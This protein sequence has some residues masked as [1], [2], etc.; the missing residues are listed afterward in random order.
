M[1]PQP[2]ILIGIAA[3]AAILGLGVILIFNRLVTG[4]QLVREGWSGIDVQLKRRADLIPNLVEVVRG[5]ANH[6]RTLLEELTRLR[7]ATLQAATVAEQR[8]VAD[9]MQAALQRLFVVAEAYPNL[10][11]DQS[12][13][14]LQNELVNLEDQIQMARRYY[15]GTVRDQNIRIESFPSN[16]VAGLF[17]FGIAEYFGIEDGADR[18]VPRARI[19]G[20]GV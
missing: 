8:D 19:G 15:N 16:L 2:L 4:R 17:G 6:E 12:F 7:G 3:L 13:L 18:Q 11:A 1:P 10:K 9:R 5:Y 20:T 14:S